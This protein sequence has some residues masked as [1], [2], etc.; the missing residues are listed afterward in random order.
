MLAILVFFKKNN[1]GP[2]ALQYK[3]HYNLPQSILRK[4]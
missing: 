2:M 1:S 3:G 4:D